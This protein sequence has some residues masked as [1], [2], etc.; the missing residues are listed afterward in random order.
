MYTL[1]E[2][3]KNIAENVMGKLIPKHDD[4]GHHYQFAGSGAIVDSVTQRN[5]IE[6]PHLR[7]WAVGLAI[8]FFEENDRWQ[9]LKGPMRDELITTAK[10]LHRD[11]RDEAGTIGGIAHKIIEEYVKVWIETGVKP[12]DIR[13]FIPS[14][15][16]DHRIWGSVRSAESAFEKYKVIPV[17]YELLVGVEKEGAGTLDLLVLN[18]E[19]ELELFDWKTSNSVNDFYALQTCAYRNYFQKMTGLKVKHVKIFKL[20]K[21]S[22]RFKCYIVPYPN[23]AYAAFKGLS[24]AYDWIH[25]D[26]SKKLIED[27]VRIKL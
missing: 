2:V 3:R 20:D 22:N 14:H 15:V 10:L 9:Q 27:K 25:K 16:I 11:I 4:K 1:E 19:K 18:E 24:K 26:E 23:K 13:T 8:D 12:E 17:A 5:I 21:E 7:P 6:M